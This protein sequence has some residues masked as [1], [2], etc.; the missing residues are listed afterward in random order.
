MSQFARLCLVAVLALP[1]VACGAST[2]NT[3][4]SQGEAFKRISAADLNNKLVAKAPVS[5]FDV[6]GDERYAQGHVPTAKHMKV[7]EVAATALPA[8]KA[9]M[10][11][12][13]CAGEK[14]NACHHAAEAAVELGYSNV[15]IMPEGIKGWEAQ[16]LP[17]E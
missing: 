9:A 1:V 14:C 2:A 4:D 13:Y 6:N 15:W 10:L 8:D 7:D 3:A 5:V 11:V 16:R 12:F 17:V